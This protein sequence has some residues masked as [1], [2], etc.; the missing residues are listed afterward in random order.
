MVHIHIT[1]R[2][3]HQKY[4]HL[5]SWPNGFR[6]IVGPP[7]QLIHV[8]LDVGLELPVVF[9][10]HAVDGPNT[11]SRGAQMSVRSC[12]FAWEYLE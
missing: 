12:E 1:W 7:P 3:F 6:G 2:Y 10:N 4:F 9:S 5:L 8:V 11:F